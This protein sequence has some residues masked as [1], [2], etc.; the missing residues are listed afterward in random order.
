MRILHVEDQALDADLARRAIAYALPGSTVE[1][2]ATLADARARIT[3]AAPPYDAVLLDLH[4]PDGDGIELIVEIRA[5]ALPL[6]V[7]ALT[8]AGEEQVALATLKAGADDYLAKR[9]A[10]ESRLGPT[11]RDAVARLRAAQARQA[12]PLRVLYAEHEPVDIDLTRRQLQ[13]CAPHIRLDIVPDADAA[14]AR[15]PRRADEAAAYDA[16]LVDYLLPGCDGLELLRTLR[17]ALGLDLPVVLVTG[18]GSEEV[19]VLAMQLGATDYLVKH[20]GYLLAL[21]ATIEGA[22]HRVDAAR[23]RAS[24]ERRVAARTAELEAAQRELEAFTYSASHDLR[25]PLRSIDALA[26]LLQS[27]HG[28][29]LDDAG[30]RLLALMRESTAQ[31]DRL[32]VG[33]LELSRSTRQ[34]LQLGDV[35]PA[36]LVRH[37]LDEHRDEIRT[38]GVEVA[39][40]ALPP[41]HGDLTLL[42]QVWANLIGNALKYTR[43][44]PAARIEIGAEPGG[45]DAGPVYF[46]RDNGCGFDMAHAGKLFG[47]F[48]R[49]HRADEYEGTGVGLAIVQRLVQRH[50]GRIWAEAAPGAGACLRFTLGA[51]RPDP[52]APA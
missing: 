24:L 19:A 48:C 43:R 8:S 10:F 18:Q 3:A 42:R 9:D 35:Q 45:A 14:L 40:G 22:V 44:T 37:V 11:L 28:G 30:R 1:R 46:V 50:G 52:G 20:E 7:V 6:A 12:R 36:L 31:M 15:L 13:A 26:A 23:E 32:L 21:A 16:V 51:A 5:R 25:A 29:A 34:P 17:Q 4:L 38:R 33:L 27:E 2:A 41:C 47:A 49:L 39:V